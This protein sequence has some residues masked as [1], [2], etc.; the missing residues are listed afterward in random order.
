M[1]SASTSIRRG[2]L[3][4]IEIAAPAPN[5]A[6]PRGEQRSSCNNYRAA[7]RQASCRGSSKREK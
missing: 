3:F 7:A 6:N 2:Y 1:E 5:P 4:F